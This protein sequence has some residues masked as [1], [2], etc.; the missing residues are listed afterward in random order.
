MQRRLAATPSAEVSDYG[1]LMA[2]PRR[3]AR[4]RM[5][6]FGAER[7]E[8]VVADNTGRIA[9]KIGLFPWRTGLMR[10]TRNTHPV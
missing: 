1:W 7:I 5:T 2:S 4:P 6:A 3:D 8:S 9:G 10:R